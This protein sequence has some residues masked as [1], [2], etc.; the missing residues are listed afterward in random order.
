MKIEFVNNKYKIPIH[1]LVMDTLVSASECAKYPCG[2]CLIASHTPECRWARYTLLRDILKLVEL[3][4]MSYIEEKKD[5]YQKLNCTV[6]EEC[7]LAARLCAISSG[8]PFS[9]K[10]PDAFAGLPLDMDFDEGKKMIQDDMA[11]NVIDD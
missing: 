6:E 2:G 10:C 7:F 8:Y 5:T 1:L 4:F 9:S 3:D 11:A